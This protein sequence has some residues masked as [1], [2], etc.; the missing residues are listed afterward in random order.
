MVKGAVGLYVA[1]I[2]ASGWWKGVDRG[3]ELGIRVVKRRCGVSSIAGCGL[4]H[5]DE[6][7]ALLA[8]G[9]LLKD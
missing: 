6:I 4:A 7:A 9:W 3:R 8:V 1:E 2:F 5:K